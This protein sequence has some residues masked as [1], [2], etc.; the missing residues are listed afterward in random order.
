[1]RRR[2]LTVLF[3]LSLVGVATLGREIRIPVDSSLSGQVVVGEW[4][5]RNAGRDGLVPRQFEAWPD[6]VFVKSSDDFSVR[7]EAHPGDVI[8]LSAGQ[9]VA[10][11]FVFTSNLTITTDPTAETRAE[12]WGTVEIDADRVTLDRIAVIGPRKEASSGHGIEVNRLLVRSIAIRN[13]RV[14]GKEW[15]GIHIIAPNGEIDELRVENCELVRNGMDGMD[16]QSVSHLVITG[17]TITDNGW[18]FDHGVGV[19][20]GSNVLSADMHDNVI[21]RNRFAD[22]YH[23]TEN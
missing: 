8:V 7:I 6:E 5:Y 2:S 17:C 3:L 18:N 10:D 19:R 9:Y 1:M 20:I 11:L 12:I 4:F 16:A 13:C 14:E 15:T 22:V 23:R 21:E